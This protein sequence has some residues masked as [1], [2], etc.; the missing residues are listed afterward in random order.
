MDIFT[1]EKSLEE[2]LAEMQGI[3]SRRGQ[4]VP[5]SQI[6]AEWSYHV[7]LV[8]EPIGWRALWKIPR[9]TCQDFNVHYPTIVLVEVENVHFKELTALA[10]IIGVQDDSIH[11]PEKYDVPLVEMYPTTQQPDNA[12]N[13]FTTANCIDRLR[14]FF[15]YL[16]MP[17]DIDDDDNA[18]W[19]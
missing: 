17:W 8:I 9:F 3:L 5:S 11:L 16:F 6:H 18:D 12:I 14:F 1:Y 2:R 4:I 15:D 19:V 10:K 13:I 7:E